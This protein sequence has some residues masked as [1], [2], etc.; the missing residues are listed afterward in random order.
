MMDKLRPI[1]VGLDPSLAPCDAEVK[2]AFHTLL[3]V[4]GYPYEFLWASEANR[5]K[6][7]D[8]YYGPR[9]RGIAA[10]VSIPACGRNFSD[11]P[12]LEPR[13]LYEN[14]GVPYLDF[15]QGNGA[16]YRSDNGSLKFT[17]D[18]I[19]ACYWL[20]TGAREPQYRRDRWDNLHLDGTFFLENSLAS[21]PLVSIYGSLLRKHFQQMGYKPLNFPWVSSG[22]DAAFVFTHD[23]DYPQMIRWIECFRLL[24]ARG[25][26]GL[27]SIGGVLRG[28]NHFWKFSDWVEFEKNIGTRPAFYFIARQGS[29][30]QYAMGTPDG[31]YDIRSPQFRKLFSYLKDEG[32]EVSLHASYNAFRDVTRLMREKQELEEAAGVEVSGNRHHCWH[33]NPVAPIETLSMHE[34][35]ELQY[36]S[37]LGFEFYPGFRR[38][39][40]HPYRNYHPS[41]RRELNVVE[42][43][44]AWMD[45][46][47]DRR[48]P[49]NKIAEPNNYAQDLVGVARANGGIITVDYHARGMNGDIYPHY[50]SWLMEYVR[51]HLDKSVIFRTPREL[52]RQYLE[53][54]KILDVHSL[55]LAHSAQEIITISATETATVCSSKGEPELSVDFLR[56]EEFAAW[57]NFVDE[58]PEGTIY[59]TLAWKAVTEEG[60]GHRAYYLRALNASGQ[61]VGVLPLF[62]VK[63]LFGRRLV[64]LPMR[65]RGG[66]LARDSETASLLV[67]RAIEMTR[68]LPCKYLELRSF[69]EI[70]LHILQQQLLRCERYWITTRIDLSPGVE[71]LWKALDKDS[72]R[73][74]IKKARKNGVRVEIDNTQ[75]GMEMFYEMF[76]RTRCSMG[77]PPFP[78]SMFLSIWHHLITQGKANLFLVWKDSEPITGMINFLSKDTFIPAYA[79]PQNHWRK[80]YPSESVFWHAIEWATKQGFRYL[81]FGADSPAQTGLLWFKKKWGGVQHP[82][83]YYYFLNGVNTPLNFDSSAPTH[84]LL[85]KAWSYFPIPLSKVLGGWVTRQLS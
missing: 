54:E 35:V 64:S 32:C 38:G 10:S 66:V 85:R 67:S 62:L 15:G 31:F 47:F 5:E 6:S 57:D 30:L 73:W 17:N 34:Q 9:E 12:D 76:V 74:A 75:N 55:D 81:D 8:I 43:P 56:S 16:A 59:H 23:V 2:Y 48:L 24:K 72:V 21:K 63:G 40:C 53:Y 69:V 18:I 37:S 46:H 83:F 51:N 68:E 78:K 33:I 79:A 13:E 7:L 58:H 14:D 11:A 52:V 60:L 22:K 41:E 29:L 49:K 3:R 19:F 82:M 1:R 84:A 28:T 71:E 25:L 61:F 39:I 70:D 27:R 44:P 80:S 45:D 36:D 4:A 20:L 77:I 42:L 65:D 26:K 50:G